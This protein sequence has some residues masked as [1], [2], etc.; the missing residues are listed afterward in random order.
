[1]AEKSIAAHGRYARGATHIFVRQVRDYVHGRVQSY[2]RYEGA[3]DYS[4]QVPGS[5]G[6]RVRDHKRAGRMLI[7]ISHGR[8][9]HL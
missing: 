1:M 3:S 6:G 7:Y 8:V 5:S 9:D 2:N 4:F